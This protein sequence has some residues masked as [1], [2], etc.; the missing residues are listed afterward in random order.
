M[1]STHS[2]CTRQPVANT[3]VVDAAGGDDGDGGGDG[4][5]A[6][7][8]FVPL[9]ALLLFAAIVSAWSANRVPIA[10]NHRT[11]SN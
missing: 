1:H 6:A 4:G 2:N 7:V 11:H 3:C 8:G 10:S 5:S 9:P